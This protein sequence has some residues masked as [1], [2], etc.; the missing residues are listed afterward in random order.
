MIR[1]VSDSLVCNV[2]TNPLKSCEMSAKIGLLKLTK[3]IDGI[4]VR[5]T[6]K[7][8]NFRTNMYLTIRLFTPEAHLFVRAHIQVAGPASEMLCLS[9]R[10]ISYLPRGGNTIIYRQN[11]I[12]L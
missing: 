11:Y 9:K 6:L 12:T 7:S 8:S 2:V 10:I 3:L 1:N 5:G 4:L